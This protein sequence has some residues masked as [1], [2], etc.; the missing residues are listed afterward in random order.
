[1]FPTLWSWKSMTRMSPISCRRTAGFRICAR[2]L[3]E[4]SLNPANCNLPEIATQASHRQDS[5]ALRATI[6]AEHKN[7]LRVRLLKQLRLGRTLQAEEVR[8][9]ASGE[10]IADAAGAG[11]DAAMNV[12]MDAIGDRRRARRGLRRRLRFH[13]RLLRV[14]RNQDERSSLGRRP[15]INQS[16]CRESQFQ[17]TKG[18]RIRVRFRRGI[19]RIDLGWRTRVPIPRL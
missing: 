6:L 8:P 13:L 18:C 2:N 4:A 11:A 15:D 3:H 7:N 19:P 12:A 17:S 5:R 16:C 10:V 14:R 1:M 9:T